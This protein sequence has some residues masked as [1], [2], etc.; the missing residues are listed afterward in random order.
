M[1]TFINNGEGHFELSPDIFS[2]ASFVAFGG[3]LVAFFAS[4]DGFISGVKPG[5]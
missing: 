5:S 2:A 3:L 4:T 1:L